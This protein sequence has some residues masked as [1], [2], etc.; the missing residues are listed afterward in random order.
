MYN[1]FETTVN[2]KFR[3]CV[4]D[5]NIV[6]AVLYMCPSWPTLGNMSRKQY[7]HNILF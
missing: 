1:L 5:I 7:P 6:S 4:R 2:L 3:S